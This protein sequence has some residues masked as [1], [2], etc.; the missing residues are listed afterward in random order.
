MNQIIVDNKSYDV[1]GAWNELD[2]TQLIQIT[3]TLHSIDHP[4]KQILRV[5]SA[6]LKVRSR[7]WL[8]Y[9]LGLK[10][11][12]DEKIDTLADLR[13]LS[14]WVFTSEVDLT[15][16][17]IKNIRINWL[18]P[19]WTLYGPPDGCKKLCFMEFIKAETYF[20][21]FRF[22]PFNKA[23][24]TT[25]LNNLVATLY[26]PK[27]THMDLTKFNGDIRQEYND[28]LIDY[29]A[30]K[31]TAKISFEIKLSIALFYEGCRKQREKQFPNI[32]KKVSSSN[33]SKP[34]PPNTSAWIDALRDMAGGALKM[35]ELGKTDVDIVL[36]D[37][38]KRII[39]AKELKSKTSSRRRS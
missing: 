32:F 26:R 30:E 27:K 12:G 2:R 9:I 28:D 13:Y 19:S 29:L 7:I 35:E 5:V 21:N 3:K 36:F 31:Y 38:N 25:A 16:Q 18:K 6:L 1:P 11:K 10:L 22:N 4:D 39:E 24:R 14:Q 37:L 20:L 23:V 34:E 15:K 33:E 17:L 8:A